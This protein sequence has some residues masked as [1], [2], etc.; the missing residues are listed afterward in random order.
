MRAQIFPAAILVA[1]T[2]LAG[3]ALLPA[4]PVAVRYAEGLAHGFL[5]LRTLD[6]TLLASGDLIQ[7]ARGGLVTSQVVFRFRDGS[8]QDETATFS[9]RDRFRLMTYHL[10]Q[11]GPAFPQPL[12]MTINTESGQVTVRYRDND[13]KEKVENERLDLP[14]DLANGIVPVL[15]KNVGAKNFPPTVSYVAATPKPRLVK[16]ALSTA[17][18][19]TFSV[20]GASRKATHYVLKAE[21]G[22]LAGMLAPMVGKQPPDNHVWIFEGEAPA[23][24]KSEQPLYVGGPSWRIELTSPVWPAARPAAKP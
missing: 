17:G 24:V 3:P 16:L 8:L 6:G 4:D 12:D 1:G 10:V 5:A 21:I 14:A 7:V 2:T 9:Q 19:D 20:A 23:F 15:L 13:G 11:K 18:A 22:G